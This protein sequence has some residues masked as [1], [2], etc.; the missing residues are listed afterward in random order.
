MVERRGEWFEGDVR[1]WGLRWCAAWLL[2]LYSLVGVVRFSG[3]NKSQNGRL[4]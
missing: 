1:G 3:S 4:D 2:V